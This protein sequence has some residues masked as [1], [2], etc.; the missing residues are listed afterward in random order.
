MFHVKQTNFPGYIL[1]Y[2]EL[3]K[4]LEIVDTPSL[5]SNNLHTKPH[6]DLKLNHYVQA[7]SVLLG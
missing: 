1:I 4:Q 3:C 2:G 5:K 7:D 6:I